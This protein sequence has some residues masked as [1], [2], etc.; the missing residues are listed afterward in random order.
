LDIEDHKVE[1]INFLRKEYKKP[2]VV[3]MPDFFFDR[4]INVK[5]NLENFSFKISKIIQQKGGS[6]DG[7]SQ[8]DCKGGNAINTAFALI[9]LGVKVTPIICTNENGINKI[10][11]YL[12]N[13][14]VDL[15][16]IKIG[17][18]ASITTALEFDFKNKKWIIKNMAKK[19]K[20]QKQISITIEV[21]EKINTLA[22]AGFGLVAALAWNDAIKSLFSIIFPKSENNLIAQ[23]TYALLITLIV[24]LI[25]IYLARY[26]KKI[27]N[28]IN[29]KQ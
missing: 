4:I 9:T 2:K 1:L 23:F 19:E 6:L 14:V 24:V 8:M 22:A 21:F 3:V 18:K 29:G 27:K 20:T 28:L 10:R 17:K 13:E 7:L 12:K 15:S 11:S 16:H 5:D 25:T 26:I